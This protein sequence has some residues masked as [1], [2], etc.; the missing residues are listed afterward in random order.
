MADDALSPESDIKSALETAD[1]GRE[2]NPPA[3]PETPAAP[4]TETPPEVDES[5]ALARERG[6]KPKE[7]WVGDQSKWIDASAYNEKYERLL[8]LR[9]DK[10]NRKLAA[11]LRAANDRIAELSKKSGEWEK[12]QTE[13]AD[14]RAKLRRDTLLMERRQAIEDHDT[15]KLMQVDDEL[16]DLRVKESTKP[17]RQ[18]TEAQVDPAVKRT[19]EDFVNDNPVFKDARMGAVLS[20]QA[21]LMRASGSQLRGRD[22]LDEAMDRV[23]RMYPEQFRNGAPARRHPLG[24]TGGTPTGGGG[25]RTRTWNDLKPEAKEALDKF[26]SSTPGATREGILKSAGEEY[27]RT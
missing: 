24:E 20:E 4:A 22:F 8:P 19:L 10:D 26:I 2:V 14:A 11:E 23:K 13:Q 9:L 3:E 27:F 5:A 1:W 6:W 17:T 7:D 25:R 15:D 12:F 18:T 16:L 21:T